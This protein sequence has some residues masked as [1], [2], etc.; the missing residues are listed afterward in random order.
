MAAK[1]ESRKP[2]RFK[3]HRSEFPGFARALATSL[4]HQQAQ[5]RQQEQQRE[6]KQGQERQQQE[7][8]QEPVQQRG[9]EQLG[10]EGQRVVVKR[11][12]GN[13][14]QQG[15]ATQGA[16]HDHGPDRPAVE[17]LSSGQPSDRQH[18]ATLH[19]AAGAGAAVTGSRPPTTASA[20]DEP[21]ASAATADVPQRATRAG[22]APPQSQP[23]PREQPTASAPPPA[24]EPQAGPPAGHLLTENDQRQNDHRQ[25]TPGAATHHTSPTIP[26][27]S[28]LGSMPMSQQ[29]AAPSSTPGFNTP[30]ASAGTSHLPPSTQPRL[31]SVQQVVQTQ[32][33]PAG[34]A[35]HVAQQQDQAGGTQ[36]ELDTDMTPIPS[37]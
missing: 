5:D 24:P 15:A 9:K 13:G 2:K 25:A 32:A 11:Q 35:G 37:R 3:Y 16:G 30:F 34:D 10:K 6:T 17:P 20:R 14:A 33:T 8:Q 7:E 22:S 36:A 12:K 1:R 28:P 21:P 31:R 26:G 4:G 29:G 27:G 18:T 23:Q 19:T